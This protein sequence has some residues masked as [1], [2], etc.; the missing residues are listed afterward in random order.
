[1]D[2]NLGSL[3]SV[4]SFVT[5]YKKKDLPLHILINNAGV[6]NTPQGKTEDGFETQLGVMFE[7]FNQI[8]A[9]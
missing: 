1:M 7:N 5:E 6:M 4:R 9:D 2:L 8:C 3:K